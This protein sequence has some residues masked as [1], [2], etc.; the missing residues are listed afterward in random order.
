ML[1][2]DVVFDIS[3]DLFSRNCNISP[4]ITQLATEL[5]PLFRM[6]PR[7]IARFRKQCA[8]CARVPETVEVIVS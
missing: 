5:T 7:L 2:E 8:V 6:V 1:V 3:Q 4:L